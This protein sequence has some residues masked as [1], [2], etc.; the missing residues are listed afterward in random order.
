MLCSSLQF[1]DEL[2][3]VSCTIFAGGFDIF[4]KIVSDVIILMRTTFLPSRI[5]SPEH[6]GVLWV[7]LY[8][9]TRGSCGV[10]LLHLAQSNYFKYL[11]G[12]TEVQ[13]TDNIAGWLV[14]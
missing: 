11:L 10:S 2:K 14:H 6:L 13:N 3:K 5:F 4:L 12:E 9:N 7:Q 8:P 1:F